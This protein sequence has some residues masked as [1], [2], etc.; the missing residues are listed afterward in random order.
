MLGAL[1]QAA[2]FLERRFLLNAV[3]PSTI[4]WGALVLVYTAT[5]GGIAHTARAWTLQDLTLRV[6]LL[7]AFLAWVWFS[8][9]II[10]SQWANMIRLYEGYYWLGPLRIIGRLGQHWHQRR[11]LRLSERG[12]TE[13]TYQSYPSVYRLDEVMP[14]R[15]GNIIKTA[16]L[17]STERYDADCVL[18][19][20]RLHHLFPPSFVAMVA[21]ARASL[22]LLLVI[23]V[24]AITFGISAGARLLWAGVRWEVFLVVYWGALVTAFLTYLGA[25]G[26]ARSYGQQLRVGFDLYRTELIRQMRLPLPGTLAE[27]RE[28][29]KEMYF[30]FVRNVP[31]A[32]WRFADVPISFRERLSLWPPRSR[33]GDYIQDDEEPPADDAEERRG[34]SET[35]VRLVG[36]QAPLAVWFALVAILTGALGAGFLHR[37]ANDPVSTWVARQ[38]LPV[39]HRVEARELELR[40]VPRSR[41]ADG[42][43]RQRTAIVGHY[44]LASIPKGSPFPMDRLGPA[45]DASAIHQAVILPIQTTQLAVRST[46]LER[47]AAVNVLF[48]GRTQPTRP[49][50]ILRRVLILD[51]S[52]GQPPNDNTTTVTVA[53]PRAQDGVIA[54]ID[55]LQPTFTRIGS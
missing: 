4:F 14:T 2:G 12:D 17:Y 46:R 53:V 32:W 43:V 54:A 47:G 16:E 26:S 15:L 5:D 34:L 42:S 50:V 23:S 25:I 3:L 27:E 36:E 55:G 21:D 44:T 11:L 40:S 30:F 51:I 28:R 18:L 24:L 41:L 13:Q 1:S 35:L 29:W 7:L 10:A 22:E 52:V 49:L 31:P 38:D 39:F 20:P 45:V 37:H 48:R 19:W 9:S 8:A 33:L 6:V